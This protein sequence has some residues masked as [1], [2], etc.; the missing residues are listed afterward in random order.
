MAFGYRGATMKKTPAIP[1]TPTEE[2]YLKRVAE[3]EPL[4]RELLRKV[5]LA[6]KAADYPERLSGGQQQRFWVQS[7]F[8]HRKLYNS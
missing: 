4:A 2:D 8:C 3:A 7:L 6:H 1:F 5:G